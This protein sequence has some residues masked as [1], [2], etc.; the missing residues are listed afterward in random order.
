VTRTRTVG[1]R[2]FVAGLVV[3]GLTCVGAAA[4]TP[5]YPL[6]LHAR[7]APASGTSAA[8]QFSG[9]LV[10]NIDGESKLGSPHAV[11]LWAVSLRGVHRPTTSLRLSATSGAPPVTRTLCTSCATTARGRTLLTNAQGLRIA[12]SDATIVVRTSSVTLRGSVKVSA[13]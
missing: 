7:L 3:A 1:K 11:L 12:T 9:T 5:S 8:G 6:S 13:D 4:A 10:M 2:A